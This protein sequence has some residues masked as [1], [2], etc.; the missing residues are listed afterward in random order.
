M[1]QYN[2][3]NKIDSDNQPNKSAARR[4]EVGQR[5][6]VSGAREHATE[7]RTALG[8]SVYLAIDNSFFFVVAFYYLKTE[9]NCMIVP[10]Q[11]I[12]K[13]LR[14]LFCK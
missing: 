8:M 14:S 6:V 4:S 3:A 2:T 13:L 7:K 9:A 5:R 12:F 1:T 10:H 11:L